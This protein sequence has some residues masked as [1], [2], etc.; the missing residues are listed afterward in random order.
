M[1]KKTGAAGE[2]AV[3][4]RAEEGEAGRSVERRLAEWDGAVVLAAS[5]EANYPAL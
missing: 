1:K 5:W 3:R 2:D 4:R